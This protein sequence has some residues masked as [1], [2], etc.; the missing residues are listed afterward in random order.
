MDEA[1]KKT[2]NE[3]GAILNARKE[4]VRQV[5]KAITEIKAECQTL[6]EDKANELKI[7]ADQILDVFNKQLSVRDI[8]ATDNQRTIEKLTSHLDELRTLKAIENEKMIEI[9][10]K[11]DS[12]LQV[13]KSVV[14]FRVNVCF[15]HFI[16]ASLISVCGDGNNCGDRIH[17]FVDYRF[18]S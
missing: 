6:K 17:N 15:P 8:H 4:L 1:C 7:L 10:S 5:F 18:I 9:Q 3:N 11:K 13:R 14:T 2:K 12:E 16:F